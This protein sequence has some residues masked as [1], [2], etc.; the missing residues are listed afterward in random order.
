LW[1]GPTMLDHKVPIHAHPRDYAAPKQDC[2]EG[3][4]PFSDERTPQTAWR[5]GH[6]GIRRRRRAALGLVQLHQLAAMVIR[7]SGLRCRDRH[8]RR[9]DRGRSLPDGIGVLDES[10]ALGPLVC[11][12]RASC[13]AGPVWFSPRGP[14]FGYSR[15]VC[16]DPEAAR[17]RGSCGQSRPCLTIRHVLSQLTPR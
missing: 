13:Q 5:G 7:T 15:W 10:P 1:I 16:D 3:K 2:D 4:A 17:P 11:R 8:H 6:D 12:Q 9:I 14:S